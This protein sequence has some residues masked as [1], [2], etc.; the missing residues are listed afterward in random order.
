M[1]LPI[2]R[3]SDSLICMVKKFWLWKVY[4]QTL[5]RKVLIQDNNGNTGVSLFTGALVHKIED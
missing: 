1:G 4:V 5:K 3:G 2:N